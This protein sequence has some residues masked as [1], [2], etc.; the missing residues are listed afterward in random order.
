MKK[1]KVYKIFFSF[2]IPFAMYL[3]SVMNLKD[4]IVPVRYLEASQ[5]GLPIH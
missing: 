2:P 3:A 5:L 1:K 4:G